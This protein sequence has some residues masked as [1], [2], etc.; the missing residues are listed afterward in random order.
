MVNIE[1]RHGDRS[2]RSAAGKDRHRRDVGHHRTDQIVDIS[3]QPVEIPTS[4]KLTTIFLNADPFG[5]VLVGLD[6]DEDADPRSSFSA[7]SRAT[8]RFDVA[9]AFKFLNRR[10]QGSS[11]SPTR[12]AIS[13]ME[14]LRPPEASPGSFFLRST[15]RASGLQI[16]ADEKISVDH[17][18]MRPH[19]TELQPNA[20]ART[21]RDLLILS[22]AGIACG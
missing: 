14:G 11:L 6:R 22:P 13:C 8:R 3:A 1:I 20:Y 10:Q 16:K 18:L 2:W 17:V 19:M 5:I 21:G 9:A 12:S 7:S 15:R 4:G